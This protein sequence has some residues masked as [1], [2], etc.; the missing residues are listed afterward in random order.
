MPIVA[1]LPAIAGAVGIGKT[2]YDMTQ[3]GGEE[4][5]GETI[6]TIPNWQNAL[7]E[8]MAKWSSQALQN[9]TPGTAYTGKMTA[10]ISAF[11][12]LGLGK[13]GDYLNA[14][15]TGD[16]YNAGRGQIM[17]T[18][19]GK[20]MTPETSPYLQAMT[21]MGQ[22]NLADQISQSRLGAGARGN[23]FGSQAMDQES[24]LRENTTNNLNALIGQ[25]LQNE[26]QNQISVLP[27]AASYEQYGKMTAPLSQ[28]SASQTYGQLPRLLEQAEYENQYQDYVRQREEMAGAVNTGAGL[29]GMQPYPRTLTAPMRNE[30]SAFGR[31]SGIT[32]L[33]SKLMGGGK[34]GGFSNFTEMA[35]VTSNLINL[36][37]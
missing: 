15:V 19:S 26:R 21:R 32:D 6:N 13:L 29:A 30:E 4:S 31:V 2:V 11:E 25:F 5:G 37:G 24:R 33:L 3:G 7:Q 10:P 27:Q 23:Y 36:L 8:Q 35:P 34:G 28:I 17:D 9:Y 14:P 12:Q 20:Y 16:L 18:L 22:R 1:A